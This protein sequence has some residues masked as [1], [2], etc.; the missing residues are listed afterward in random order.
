MFGCREVD[1]SGDDSETGEAIASLF[2]HIYFRRDFCGLLQ[3]VSVAHADSDNDCDSLLC[4]L[5]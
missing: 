3:K 4:V 5:P 1:I 2:S